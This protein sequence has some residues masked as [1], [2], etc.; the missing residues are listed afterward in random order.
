MKKVI[1]TILAATVLVAG[2]FAFMPINKAS[3]IHSSINSDIID[4]ERIFTFNIDTPVA[5]ND[6]ALVVSADT[7]ALTGEIAAKLID[8]DNAEVVD[9]ECHNLGTLV[10]IVDDNNADDDGTQEGA[11]LVNAADDTAD[12]AFTANCEL[13][14]VDITAGSH[15]M[16]TVH[17]D[18]WPEI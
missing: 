2:I 8:A 13:I 5:L 17:I 10:A 15:V 3:T 6:V 12:I 1:P 4:Q 11:T 7:F 14:T 16:I 9:I 18:N